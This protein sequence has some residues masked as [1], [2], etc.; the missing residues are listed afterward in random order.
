MQRLPNVVPA[1]VRGLATV[2][3]RAPLSGL[4]AVARAK[5]EQITAQWKGT[6]GSGENVKNYIGGKFIDSK[7][8]L[9][10]DLVDPV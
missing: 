3:S 10:I 1:H 4:N 8:D 9:W 7:A 2:V 5:A 6:N